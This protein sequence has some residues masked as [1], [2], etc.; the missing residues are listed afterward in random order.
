MIIALI[1]A[2]S[3]IL[4]LVFVV[5][6]LTNTLIRDGETIDELREELSKYQ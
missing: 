1:I 5:I 2:V 6:V 3:I 4:T